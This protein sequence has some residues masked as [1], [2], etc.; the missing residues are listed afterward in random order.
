MVDS[1]VNREDELDTLAGRFHSDTAELV[2]IYGR[3]LGKS[4][5]VREA[6]RDIDSAVYWQ[7]TE[8]TADIQVADFVDTAS[9]VFPVIDDVQRD[10]EALLRTLG[11]ENAVVVLDEFP[12]LAEADDARLG[13]LEPQRRSIDVLQHP[14]VTAVE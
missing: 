8:E 4:A 3:R 10:W 9:G 11:R 2:V 6:V 14:E 5:L 7:A 13:E 1:F 12:Y